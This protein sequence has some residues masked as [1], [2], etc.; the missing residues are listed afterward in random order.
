MG[1]GK[2]PPAV[3]LGPRITGWW[4]SDL[5]RFMQNLPPPNQP[6]PVLWPARP[7]AP[8]WNIGPEGRK[9]RKAGG[10]LVVDLLTGKKR[11]VHHVEIKRPTIREE[12]CFWHK[13]E[14]RRLARREPDHLDKA[15]E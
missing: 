15:A 12:D 10:R 4:Q 8:L 5:V 3:G 1:A 13:A 9:G 2:F 14:A 6:L 7:K 11:Y